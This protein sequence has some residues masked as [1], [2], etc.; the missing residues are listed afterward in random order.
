MPD[1]AHAPRLGAR[2]S[3]RAPLILVVDDDGEM[4]ATMCRVLRDHGYRPVPASQGVDANWVVERRGGEIALVVT[5]LLP[6][7]PD[8][9]HLGI[10][11]ERLRPYTPV[12]FTARASREENIRRGLL[13]P[14]APYVRK[15]F[16]PSA[17]ARCVR[18]VIARW[19]ALPAA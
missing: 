1:L 18:D 11:Y 15:P 8:G 19:P 4:R 10:P 5:D 9:Y 3:R 16:A 13:H 6:P 7:A 14:A 12:L 2:P 17:F